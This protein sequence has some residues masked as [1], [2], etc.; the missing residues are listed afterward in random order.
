MSA[1]FSTEPAAPG[2]RLRPLLWALLASHVWRSLSAAWVALPVASVLGASGVR[3][4]PGGDTRLFADGGLLLLEALVSQRAELAALA[5][6]L[7]WGL[8][9]ASFAALGPEW[10]VL[11]ALGPRPPATPR[12]FGR[13]V[14]L[15]AA[16]WGLRLGLS[17]AT[18][19][20]AGALRAGLSG[21][22]DERL[23]DLA[24]VS[25]L[26]LGLLLQGGISVLR[27]LG[28]SEIAARHTRPQ[29]AL[30]RALGCLR[31]SA[32][33]LAAT[34][35]GL[36]LL[37]LAAVTL[38]AAAADALDVG[39]GGGARLA[40]VFGVHQLVLLLLLAA[41]AAWLWRCRRALDRP[42]PGA[43]AEAFL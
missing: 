43:Q 2:P 39:S 18:L 16:T 1:P 23:P 11:R 14:A 27:D 35:A 6:P 7:L 26:A 37:T 13:L 32:P 34:Y 24:A 19:L 38:G 8:L 33:R 15:G 42:E 30:A 5:A 4:W 3:S 12:G 22:R 31:A 21:A 29:R 28:A 17:V 25:V 36:A 9:V 41:R 20:F 40:A 10:L